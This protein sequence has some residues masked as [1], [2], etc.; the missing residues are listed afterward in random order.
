MRG[1]T[2]VVAGRILQVGESLAQQAHGLHGLVDAEGGLGQPDE[3]IRVIHHDVRNIGGTVDEGGALG[4]VTHGALDLFVAA[5]ADEQDLVVVPGETGGLA[6][7]LGYQR[8]GGVDR[9]QA[10][11]GC[12]LHHH[13]RDAVRAEDD[14]RSRRDLLDLIDK[15]RALPL[16]GRNDVDVVHDLFTH[17]HRCTVV[18]QRLL[19]GDH[20]AVHSSA[21]PSGG[22]EEYLLC[23]R[24]RTVLQPVALGRD[25]GGLE[26]DCPAVRDAAHPTDSI[27][28]SPAT[29]TSSRACTR[30]RP[31]HRLAA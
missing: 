17:V 21:I 1:V 3:V 20:R 31:G 22:G 2:D 23:A 27:C 15:D 29:P 16:Q 19:H 26:R 7:H 10:A 11:V 6:V 8:T 4:R 13:R 14:V 12:T 9:E 30:Q 24:D 5:V 28:A 18:L 25:P